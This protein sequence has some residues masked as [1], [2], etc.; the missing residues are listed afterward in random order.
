MYTPTFEDFSVTRHELT[1]SNGVK[2]VLFERPK[3]PISMEI[4]F[5]SGSQFDPEGKEGISHFTE[6]MTVAGTKKFPTKDRLAIFIENLGGGFRASTGLGVFKISLDVVE[7]ED[8]KQAVSLLNE[9]LNESLFDPKTI[10]TERGSILRELSS[11]E[12]A[13]GKYIWELSRNLFFQGSLCSRSTLGSKET[14]ESITKDDL[15]RFY[16]DMLTSGRAV[17]VVSGGISIDSVVKILESSL[18]LRKSEKFRSSGLLPV[19]RDRSVLTKVYTTNDLINIDFGFRV[20]EGYHEDSIPMIFLGQ[21]LG[22]GRAS[23]LT[24]KLRY[25][26]GYV[27]YVDAGYNGSIDSGVF[28][29]DTEVSKNNIQEVF[30]IITEELNNLVDKGVSEEEL[31]LVKNRSIKS[32]KGTMQTSSSWISFHAYDELFE[33]PKKTTLP[34]Y[35]ARVNS[36]TAEDVNRVCKKYLNKESWYLAM[37]GDIKEDEVTIDY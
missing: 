12:S 31:K 37:C 17:I 2:V 4:L 20:C 29:I 24:K 5:L 27:Y 21:I 6:H 28:D 30:N 18:T 33:N 16:N 11:K 36:L 8:F 10:E 34:E 9:M 25:E 1:L 14:I 7:P 22:G 35:L 23:R 15:L 3:A 19:I 32:K 26:K 13:P